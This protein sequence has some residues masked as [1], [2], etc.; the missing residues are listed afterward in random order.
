MQ[1]LLLND[2]QKYQNAQID[3]IK[4]IT[5]SR[6]VSFNNYSLD[7]DLLLINAKTKIFF[8]ELNY[9]TSDYIDNRKIG[10]IGALIDTDLFGIPYDSLSRWTDY[11]TKKTYGLVGVTETAIDFLLIKKEVLNNIELLEEDTFLYS[12]DAVCQWLRKI[13]KAGFSH[14]IDLTILLTDELAYSS[15]KIIVDR[16]EL[17]EYVESFALWTKMHLYNKR[18]AVLHYLL[19]D[20][21]DGH[22]FNVG[23]TQLHVK[24]LVDYQKYSYNVFVLA[25]DGAK[26]LLTEYVNDEL[27]EFEF[28]CDEMSSIPYYSSKIH[29]DIYQK[30]FNAI[31][32]ELVHIH[33]TMWLPLDIFFVAKANN[34]PIIFT[35]HDYYYICPELKMLNNGDLC[36]KELCINNN[37]FNKKKMVNGNAF[38]QKWRDEHAKVLSISDK[39]VFPSNFARDVF[40]KYYSEVIGKDYVI[41]HGIGL[42]DN[43]TQ[44]NHPNHER[45]R[46]AFMGNISEVKGGKVITDMI[47]DY[48]MFDWYVIGGIGYE[49]LLN[50]TGYVNLG[51]YKQEKIVDILNAN[52]IDIVCL[53]STVNETFCYTLSESLAAGIPVLA[54]DVGALGAR[55]K[56]YECGWLVDRSATAKD[57]IRMLNE[58]QQ[59][60]NEYRDKMN[61][62]R[63]LHLKNVGE[64]GKDYDEL[65][66]SVFTNDSEHNYDGKLIYNNILEKKQ[67]E[68]DSRNLEAI[69][70]LQNC[71][72]ELRELKESQLVRMAISLRKIK[73]PGK[74]FLWKMINR[75]KKMI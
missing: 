65:Y 28:D 6:I 60:S 8:S 57:V 70:Q 72:R 22:S 52:E 24:D 5:N 12:P 23:G 73:F 71:E 16:T 51:W 37:C 62:I 66:E 50:I 54:T 2:G 14:V 41:E 32:I 49:P 47:S 46:V 38:I 68:N 63:N 4:N 9:L 26:M 13:S 3:R 7:E 36:T 42:C 20:F 10:T 31:P 48:D 15:R 17:D 53:L 58:I 67:I 59:N 69:W 40:E 19:A 30:I 25:R 11:C 61:N 35:V 64:M 34:I 18:H 21:R 29:K 56:K 39:V 27:L 55:V 45:L 75:N 43:Y 33:H 74:V 1:I 44:A